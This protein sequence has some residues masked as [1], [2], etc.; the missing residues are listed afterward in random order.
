M[1]MQDPDQPL[2]RGLIFFPYEPLA[3]VYLLSIFEKLSL[4]ASPVL[5]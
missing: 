3:K 1:N 4:I 5:R 2:T